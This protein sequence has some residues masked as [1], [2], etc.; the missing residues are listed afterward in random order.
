MRCSS[1]HSLWG[2]FLKV[3]ECFLRV[4]EGSGLQVE[5]SLEFWRAVQQSDLSGYSRK[6]FSRSKGNPWTQVSMNS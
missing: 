4:S 3:S 2:A 5:G 1:V 6:N